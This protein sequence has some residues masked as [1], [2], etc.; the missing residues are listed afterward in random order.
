MFDRLRKY[1]EYNEFVYQSNDTLED[2]CK[3]PKDKSGIYIIYSLAEVG[4]EVI[5][6]G[7]SGKMKKDGKLKT[8][9]D[10]LF[11]RIVNGIEKFDG[12][13]MKRKD[14]WG[15]KMQSDGIRKI[16]VEWYV[17]FYNEIKDIPAYV[18]G[19]I[20]QEYYEAKR[21]LPSWNNSF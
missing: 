9:D 16:K 19:C 2:V 21:R 11:G 8:R 7:S 4:D 17:T 15:K 10:G 5:Y 1:K 20:I 12:K 14:M 18:E 13:R 6:I 3:A